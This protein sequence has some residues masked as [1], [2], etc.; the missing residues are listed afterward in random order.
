LKEI[1][2]GTR[3]S[4]GISGFNTLYHDYKFRAK[5]NRRAFKLTKDQTKFLF[6]SNCTY[7]GISPKQIRKVSGKRMTLKGIKHSIFKYNGIDRINNKR[8]Y[9]KENVTSCC[10]IC[11]VAKSSMN[12]KEFKAWIRRVYKHWVY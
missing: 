4:K 10:R 11:N 8:G 9:I 6:Q 12:R 1:G 5:K 7:C 2:V 3:L